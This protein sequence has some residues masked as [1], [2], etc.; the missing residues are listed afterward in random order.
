[1]RRR[2]PLD[3]EGKPRSAPSTLIIHTNDDYDELFRDM[4]PRRSMASADINEADLDAHFFAVRAATISHVW[5]FEAHRRTHTHTRT[6]LSCFC[7]SHKLW[8]SHTCSQHVSQHIESL[9]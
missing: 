6:L 7:C 2:A 5:T 1:M 3:A 9:T 8:L 4:P